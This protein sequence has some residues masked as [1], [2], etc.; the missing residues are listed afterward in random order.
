M[1]EQADFH[2]IKRVPESFGNGQV[3]LAGPGV[4]RRMVVGDDERGGAPGKR[5]FNH[6]ARM[7]MGGVYGAR[8]QFFKSNDPVPGV[9][10]QR[11]KNLVRPVPE[12]CRQIVAR[13]LRAG[14][15]LPALQPFKM[16]PAGEL[17]RRL[18]LRIFGRAQA[19]QFAKGLAADLEKLAQAVVA[20][21]EM[22]G[23]IQR[24]A[25]ASAGAQQNGQQLGIAQAG[26]AVAE[27]AFA[28][29]FRGWP[30]G[31]SHDIH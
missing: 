1:I 2:Q 10:I 22:P 29:A 28:R 26:G 23:Q 4:A 24:R 31:N 3:G 17:Q 12:F 21:D 20:A 6:H 7:D 25:P 9:E 27:Q 14:Q 8:E 19:G 11:A 15:R 5:L 18:Q 16:M 13:D 30:V